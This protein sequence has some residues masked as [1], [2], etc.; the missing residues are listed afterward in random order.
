MLTDLTDIDEIAQAKIGVE[1]W[2]VKSDKAPLLKGTKV[3]VLA[4]E[5]VKL[6]VEPVSE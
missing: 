4:I 3:K 1:T 2:T 6:I 5:G